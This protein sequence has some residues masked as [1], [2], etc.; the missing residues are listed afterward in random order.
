VYLKKKL[1]E[2]DAVVSQKF[3]RRN[4][5]LKKYLAKLLS[6]FQLLNQLISYGKTDMSR[7]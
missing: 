4:G 2:M 3:Q 5:I 7:V 6:L 1:R